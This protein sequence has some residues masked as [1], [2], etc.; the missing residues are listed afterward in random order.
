VEQLRAKEIEVVIAPVNQNGN[1][2]KP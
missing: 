1:G 2:A